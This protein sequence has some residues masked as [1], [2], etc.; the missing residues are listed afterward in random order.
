[1]PDQKPLKEQQAAPAPGN[2]EL[3]AH[4]RAAL[5]RL[6]QE[7]RLS[8]GDLLK[9]MALFEEPDRETPPGDYI[10]VVRED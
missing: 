2:Q 5:W 6:M 8:P 3:S 7:D 4:A 1:M 10:I 9:V